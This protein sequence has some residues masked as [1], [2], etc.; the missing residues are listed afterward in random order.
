MAAKFRQVL[1]SPEIAISMGFKKAVLS[2][3]EFTEHVRVVNIDEAH[4]ISVWGGTFR[5]DYAKLGLLRGR[6][7]R[8]VTMMVASATLPGHVL[9]DVRSQLRL[10]KDIKM[11]RVTNKRPNIALSIRVMQY[12]EESKAGLR[13]LIPKDAK[14]PDD[15]PPTLVYCNSRTTAEQAADQT[16][17][18]ADEMGISRDCIAYFH[19]LIGEDRKS[20]LVE[21]V[22]RGT[23]HVLYCT[24]ALGMVCSFVI[25]TLRY[26]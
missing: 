16:R 13:F 24:E 23:V 18:W 8:N 2:K 11:V 1:V 7:P 9:D 20:Q 6:F 12:S 22:T 10:S 25:G 17:D 3:T 4:C 5:P 26:I 21:H 15:I 14:S 19:A